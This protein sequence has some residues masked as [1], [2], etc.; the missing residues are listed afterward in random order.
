MK[1]HT[2]ADTSEVGLHRIGGGVDVKL[3]LEEGV[4]SIKRER[5]V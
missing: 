5:D 2:F 3:W 1:H 4:L